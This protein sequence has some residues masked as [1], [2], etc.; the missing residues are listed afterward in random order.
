MKAANK[1]PYYIRKRILTDIGQ[2]SMCWEYPERA[3]T[4][5]T[6]KAVEI[7]DALC[8]YIVDKIE[9]VKK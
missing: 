4:F 9:K 2:A 6:K 8:Q 7:G 1:V 5:D 3:G